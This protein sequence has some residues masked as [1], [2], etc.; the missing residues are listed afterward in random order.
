MTATVWLVP[1]T[2]WD[3]EWY[4]PFQRFRLR[5]VDLMD[6]VVA[7]A[8]REPDF[9]FTMDGQMAA[10]DDYLEVR[11]EQTEAV[12][13]LVARGQL[14][15]GPWR[16]LMDEFLCSGE[17]MIRNLEMGW[18]DASRLGPVMPIGYLPDMFGHCAQMPQLLRHVGI[19]Q[20][21]VYRGVP[22]EVDSHEFWWRSPDGIG[23]RTEFLVN[24][25]GNAADVFGSGAAAERLA[26]R[27][28]TQS[29]AYAG[30]FLAMYGTDHAAPLPSLMTEVA[31]LNEAANGL[32][33]ATGHGTA[34]ATTSGLADTTVSGNADPTVS[35][36]ADPTVSGPRIRVATL[37]DYL[38]EPRHPR[39]AMLVVDGELRS[40]GRANILPGVLSARWQLKEA[41]ARTERLLTRYAEPFAALHLQ[42]LPAHYLAM[43]W[44]RVIDSSCHDSV[45]GCGVDET[46]VQVLARLQEGEHAAQA[47]RDRALASAEAMSPAGAV[48]LANPL[49]AQRDDVIELTLPVP[50]P[51]VGVGFELPDGRVVPAQEI[52]RPPV[53]LAREMVAAPDLPR[54]MHRVHDRELFGLQMSRIEVDGEALRLTF[55]L[56]DHGDP[57]FDAIAAEAQLRSAATE[58]GPDAVW[59]VV[60]ADEPRRRLAAAIPVPALG[61]S[62]VRVADLTP[63]PP[64]ETTTTEASARTE[65]TATPAEPAVTPSE[66]SA[67]TATTA[68]TEPTV[69][70]AK[71]AATTA[72]TAQTAPTTSAEP[73]VTTQPASGG[74]SRGI[75]QGERALDN[76]LVQ[77]R[78]ADDG[79]LTVSADGITLRGV[80]RLVDG[81]DPGD[82]YNY[83]PPAHDVLVSEPTE[84]TVTALGSEGPVVGALRVDR[85]YELPVTSDLA[86]RSDRTE[87][88]A[89]AMHV[90]LRAGEPFVRLRLDWQNLTRDHRLRL[91]VPT[92]EPAAVSH[93]QGQLAVVERGRTAEAGPVGEH[94]LPTFPAERFVDAGGVAVLLGRTVEYEVVDAG[95]DD[96]EDD[97]DDDGDREGGRAGGGDEPGGTELAVTVLRSIG[98]L[99]RNVHPYR[100]EPAGPQLPTPD[101]QALGPCHV[102]LAVMPHQGSWAEA[103]VA[104]AAEAYLH[105]VVVTRGSGPSDRPLRSVEGLSLHGDGVE[106]V[107]LRRRADADTAVEVRVVNMSDRPTVAVLG[108]DTLPVTAAQSV[109]GLGRPHESGAGATDSAGPLEVADG[110]ARLPL[111]PWEIA[112]VK[113]EI[114]APLRPPTAD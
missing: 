3:R 62:A 57:D 16:V 19:E 8:E 93:A 84:V 49:A 37:T 79:T 1:H 77:V 35:G 12:R 41:M 107:S 72:T 85:R 23:I 68:T 33:E 10:V 100:S 105:P 2:H 98:Y 38:A 87:S 106:L 7:R 90:E 78:V 88:T 96:G 82:S 66:P 83:A 73:K 69:T 53:E 104:E 74:R 51:W 25:Y 18:A 26:A 17:T 81:G 46:A 108:S 32:A 54:L 55:H 67:T 20:A 58:S 28:A 30:D 97:G 40:H 64:T 34:G 45:T 114:A 76:G 36:N 95:E 61:W 89:V 52:S 11:P 63:A 102:S 109:D 48:V 59:D 94:P 110:R 4:E 22:A 15:I 21:V 13:A 60:T 112:A 29:Q 9:R 70:P 103:R 42:A 99:S 71:S 14:A 86:G 65:P 101:A 24:S 50:E 5:L 80:G 111:R 6:D 39:E 91:H 31:E 43:A 27:L 113:V 75:R 47:V 44:R 56:A 92:A